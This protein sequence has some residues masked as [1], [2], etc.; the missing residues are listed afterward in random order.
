MKLY[1]Q[2][3]VIEAMIKC[4]LG[5][6]NMDNMED[7]DY[8]LEYN[9]LKELNPIELPSDDEVKQ[10]LRNKHSKALNPSNVYYRTGFESG[11][12]WV[13]EQLKNK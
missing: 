10:Y 4:F 11:A 1:T 9:I 13:L 5:H 8:E 12:K 7:Y 6:S 2:Q 3:N